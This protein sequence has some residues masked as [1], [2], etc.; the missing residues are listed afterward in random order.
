MTPEDQNKWC[1]LCRTKAAEQKARKR[2]AQ[3]DLKDSDTKE[4]NPSAPPGPPQAILGKR[5]RLGPANIN[6]EP[7]PD[8][9]PQE[10]DPI[11][12]P[13]KLP[14]V[15]WTPGHSLRPLADLL[16][17]QLDYEDFSSQSEA[18]NALIAQTHACEANKEPISLS[19][20]WRIPRDGG[21]TAREVAT[22]VAESIGKATHYRFK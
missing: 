4:N 17:P 7:C 19:M 12:P 1:A 15:S 22:Q 18:I 8:V 11:P 13:T 3:R 16:V 9:P 21:M 5:T 6:V 2:A 20:R 10:K 14:K